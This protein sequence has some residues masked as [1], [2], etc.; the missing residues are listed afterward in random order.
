LYK[1]IERGRSTV[2]G[3]PFTA[4]QG[5]D[6]RWKVTIPID[7]SPYILDEGQLGHADDSEEDV[8]STEEERKKIRLELDALRMEL[9]STRA[10]RDTYKGMIEAT[11]HA[12]LTTLER[13]VEKLTA[14]PPLALP[15]P[16]KKVPWW[17]FK[18]SKG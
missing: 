12:T 13:V 3:V 7:L 2:N 16:V 5:P 11:H 14:P 6:K 9:Q 1:H 8:L 15:E 4:Q 10:E 17:R 18:K